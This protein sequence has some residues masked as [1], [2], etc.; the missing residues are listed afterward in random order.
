MF[1]LFKNIALYMLLTCFKEIIE[2]DLKELKKYLK[3]E[4]TN[5]ESH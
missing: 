4:V 5:N 3:E 1:S 2:K